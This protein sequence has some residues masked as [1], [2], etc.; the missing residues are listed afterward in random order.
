MGRKPVVH[1]RL[2]EDDI[3]R[4]IAYYLTEA[5]AEAATDFVSQLESAIQQISKHPAMGSPR[6]ALELQISGLRQVPL[7]SFPYLV[8]YIEHEK[9]I[10][11]TRVLH[12]N[13]DIPSWVEGDI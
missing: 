5:G 3:D 1:R 7:K 2:A 10:E 13:M 8:F 12:G 4:A 11:V 6:Y 9:F